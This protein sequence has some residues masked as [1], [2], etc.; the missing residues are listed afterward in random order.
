MTDVSFFLLFFLDFFFLVCLSVVWFLAMLLLLFGIIFCSV[1]RMAISSCSLNLINTMAASFL[2][3][4]RCAI[5]ERYTAFTIMV[6][7]VVIVLV[8]GKV[9]LKRLLWL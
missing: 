1:S 4:G 8:F 2:C 9:L 5:Y 3:V 7:T 6:E